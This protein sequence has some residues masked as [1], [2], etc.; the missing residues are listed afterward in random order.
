MGRSGHQA[1]PQVIPLTGRAKCPPLFIYRRIIMAKNKQLDFPE[2]QAK[3]LDWIEA[4]LQG[5]LMDAD[6]RDEIISILETF[7]EELA[8]VPK[9]LTELENG[10]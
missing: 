1:K 3:V 7:H 10:D 4:E 8:S 9:L 5:P 2:L 6:D